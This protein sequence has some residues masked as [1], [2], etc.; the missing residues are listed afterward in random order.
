MGL[1]CYCKKNGIHPL[2]TYQYKDNCDT[3]SLSSE[4]ET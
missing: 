3:G 4:F 1:K 2:D